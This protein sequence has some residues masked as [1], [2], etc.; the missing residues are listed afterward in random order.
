MCN[1][2][3]HDRQ[4]P[5]SILTIDEAAHLLGLT[6]R[7]IRQAIQPGRP[8]AERAGTSCVLRRADM[9]A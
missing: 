5:V 2:I 4:R 1:P 3:V 9:L 8:P 6:A 7:Q